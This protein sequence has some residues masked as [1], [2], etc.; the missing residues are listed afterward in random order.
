MLAGVVYQKEI[1]WTG[2]RRRTGIAE[3]VLILWG[4][5]YFNHL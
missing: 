4:W 2:L 5:W 3:H 1:L